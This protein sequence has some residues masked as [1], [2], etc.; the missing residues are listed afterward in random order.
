MAPTARHSLLVRQIRRVFE[1][2]APPPEIDAFI[3]VVDEA[4]RQFDDDRLMLERSLDLSSEELFHANA[5]LRALF[6]ALPDLVLLVEPDGTVA[7]VKAGFDEDLFMDAEAL[8]GRRL[9][10]APIR[11]KEGDTEAVLLDVL[12]RGEARTLEY[13]LEIRGEV[14]SYEARL[15]PFLGKQVILVIRDV[16]DRVLALAEL[17]EAKA[18]LELRVAER[19]A[20]LRETNE[21]LLQEIAERKAAEARR[22]RLETKL[23]QAQKLESLGVLAGGI[24]HDFNNLLMAILGNASLALEAVPVDDPVRRFLQE[25]ESATQRASG[26]TNQMLAYSGRGRFVV[27]SIDVSTVTR[28]MADL[29]E[30]SVS[31]KAKLVY[32]LGSGLPLVEADATQ[33]GQVVMNLIT[34]ASEALG[35]DGGT[36]TLRTG[37]LLLDG[38]YLS[39]CILGEDAQE[40]PY[41]FVE[42]SDD[43][44]GME[45]ETV[46]KIFDPFFTTKFTGRGL[47]LASVLGIVRGHR[48]AMRVASAPG[49]GTRFTVLLPTVDGAPEGDRADTD[50]MGR[51]LKGTVLLVDDDPAVRRVIRTALETHGY[52]AIVAEDG[53]DGLRAFRRNSDDLLCVVLDMTMPVLDGRQ[54]FEGIR[55]IS[56]VPVILISGYAR[57]E[58]AKSFAGQTELDFL[59]KPFLPKDLLVRIDRLCERRE[60]QASAGA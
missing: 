48:G 10:D 5:E 25:I 32:E 11:T 40:G 12:A 34:N 60:D 22:R 35:E 58:A 20:E 53:R 7:S 56:N 37:V 18:M 33:V 50:A 36:V 15:L 42:V 27:E 1:G 57:E 8:I 54:A 44:E 19:T 9:Q 6:K 26:L 55:E 16:T 49:N 47:G 39:E 30:V 2:G 51:P 3:D 59:Q 14:K 24:A 21:A 31:K 38:D 41:V 46:T 45:D 52:R 4:Y 29:L 28:G 13:Q 43:G 17:T 23:L